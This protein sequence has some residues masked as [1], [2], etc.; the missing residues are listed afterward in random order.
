MR[1]VTAEQM[2]EIDRRAQDEFGIPQ[3]RLME[4]A[5]RAAFDLLV[6]H[7]ST[8]RGTRFAVVCGKGNNG[9]DGL[10]LARHLS[11]STSVDLLVYAPPDEAMKPG[12]SRDNRIRVERSGIDIRDLERFNGGDA[13]NVSVVIDALFGTGFKGEIRQPYLD[14]C[15]G[16]NDMGADL[17]SLDVP[18]GLDST[19]GHAAGGCIKADRTITFGLAKTGF[20]KEDG[21]EYCGELAVA[22]IGF[23]PELIDAY[24][25]GNKN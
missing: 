10:V 4:N 18:S 12:A 2:A 19:T 24:I 21:P 23:P 3:A 20:F 8:A 11:R 15:A 1:A 5:G 9:G 25:P 7:Y 17:Y 16:M 22:D 13:E 14:I 6:R